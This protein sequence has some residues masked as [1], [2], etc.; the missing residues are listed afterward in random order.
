MYEDWVSANGT[1]QTTRLANVAFVLKKLDAKTHALTADSATTANKLASAS[2]LDPATTQAALE[3]YQAN[4]GTGAPKADW[5]SYLNMLHNNSNGY[6]T[7]LASSFHS[8]ELYWRRKTNGSLGDWKNIQ[9]SNNI[10][11]RSYTGDD[12]VTI[13]LVLTTGTSYGWYYYVPKSITNYSKA[14]R[15][16]INT[17][18][19]SIVHIM[20]TFMYDSIVDNSDWIDVICY[21]N[22]NSLFSKYRTIETGDLSTSYYTRSNKTA[23]VENQKI[24]YTSTEDIKADCFHINNNIGYSFS[25]YYFI[26]S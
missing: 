19:F 13:P 14:V 15:I 9:F 11:I 10:N 20:F 26:S 6:F 17:M 4:G 18:Y 7:Q 12:V 16:S 3:Y 21:P 1:S 24:W 25:I 5:F 2:S 22:V 8:D 23:F